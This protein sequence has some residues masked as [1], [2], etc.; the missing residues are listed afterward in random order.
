MCP[1]YRAL[2]LPSLLRQ[3][4]CIKVGETFHSNFNVFFSNN[5]STVLL[6]V[7]LQCFPKHCV[8]N[9][10]DSFLCPER[11]VVNAHCF[12]MVL[13]RL[14]GVLVARSLPLWASSGNRLR[15][16]GT[17]SL[18]K[19]L[20]EAAY[21]QLMVHLG[22]WRVRSVS[23]LIVSP[24]WLFHS[25]TFSLS[26]VRLPPSSCS[27]WSWQH[28]LKNFLHALHLRGGFPGNLTRSMLQTEM[29]FEICCRID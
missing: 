8:E 9:G 2:S 11:E 4:L 5:C 27:T 26:A 12:R 21:I 23:E 17:W 22:L 19:L 10:T 29:S 20:P 1:S 24:G 13:R 16:W 7:E 3:F 28:S 14:L 18:G 15:G 25:P 6:Q